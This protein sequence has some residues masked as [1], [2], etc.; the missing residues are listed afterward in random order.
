MA[1][2]CSIALFGSEEKGKLFVPNTEQK[3]CVIVSSKT[4]K[5]KDIDIEAVKNAIPIFNM[6]LALV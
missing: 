5:L 4:R 6:S 2:F 3:N 1:F